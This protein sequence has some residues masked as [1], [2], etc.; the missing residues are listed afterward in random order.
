MMCVQHNTRSFQ[1]GSR[2]LEAFPIITVASI[3]LLTECC[4]TD[5][6][7]EHFQS[8]SFVKYDSQL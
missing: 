8:M 7:L 3:A 4:A 5:Q 2:I 1:K 6:S